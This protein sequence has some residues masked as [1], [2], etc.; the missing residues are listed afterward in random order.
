MNFF[1]VSLFTFFLTVLTLPAL[2]AELVVMKV[3]GDTQYAVGDVIQ[4]TDT[5]EIAK[6]TSVLLISS[7]GEKIKIAGPFVGTLGGQEESAQNVSKEVKAPGIGLNVNLVQ[8]LARLF[9]K[10]VV[11]SSSLG[12]FRSLGAGVLSDPWS[13]DIYQEKSY[14]YETVTELKIWRS[15]AGRAE[16]VRLSAGQDHIDLMWKAGEHDLSW[17]A[18]L[19][20]QTATQ[21]SA[22]LANGEQ[23]AFELHKVPG[24]LPTRIHIAAWM[25]EKK[26]DQQAMLLVVNS[27]VD[28]MLEGLAQDGKF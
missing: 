6:D 13:Y 2:S 28:K 12:A 16:K 19:P 4:S 26:C 22:Q 8:S 27:D 5:I 7:L 24:D 20:A 23:V 17:P 14:C 11:D 3:D 1:R 21:Y 25:A 15:K 18:D 10:Q 9:K